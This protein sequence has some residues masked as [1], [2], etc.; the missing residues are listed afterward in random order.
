MLVSVLVP[1]SGWVIYV[2]LVLLSLLLSL[3][4]AENT[5]S[6]SISNGFPDFFSQ[7]G[8]VLL[9]STLLMFTVP[10]RLAEMMVYFLAS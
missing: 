2:V 8:S 5:I 4:T 10:F 6:S 1:S 7:I 3:F 9:G